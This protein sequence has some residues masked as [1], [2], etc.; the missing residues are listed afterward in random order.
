V[1][2]RSLAVGL[3]DPVDCNIGHDGCPNLL[4]G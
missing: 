1:N 3:A 4:V 2:H